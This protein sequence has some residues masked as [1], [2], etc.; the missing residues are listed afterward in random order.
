MFRIETL[1]EEEINILEEVSLGYSLNVSAKRM[2]CGRE[3][4]GWRIR[5]IYSKLGVDDRIKY[6]PRVR[7]LY[8]FIEHQRFMKEYFQKNLQY[9]LCPFC[10]NKMII[11]KKTGHSYRYADP[12]GHRLDKVVV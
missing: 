3:S 6:D 12:C 4:L 9:T 10:Q 5:R 2:N 8:Y 7:T 11:I 1:S